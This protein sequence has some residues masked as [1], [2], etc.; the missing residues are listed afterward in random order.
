VFVGATFQPLACSPTGGTLGAAG[1]TYIFRDFPGAG[2][3]G[4]WYH[5]AL[6]DAQFGAQLINDI[7]IISFFNSDIDDNDP[8]CLTGRTWYYG[9]D[10]NQGTNID[11]L[12]VVMH[13][14]AH[15]L[16][17]SNF[18]NEATGTLTGGF[19]DIYTKFT[20]DLTTGLT[21]DVMTNAERQASA[22]NSGN[23][24]W[25]GGNVTAEAPFVLGPRPSVSVLNP[26]SIKGSY[27]AQQASYG[28][29]LSGG[30]GTT[31]KMVVVNDG[32]GVG[33]D[34]CE[35]IQNNLNGKLALIDRGTCA[36]VTKTLNAQAAGAKGVIV[37][38]NVATGLPGM[39]GASTAAT[40]PSVGVSLAEGTAMKNA[41]QGNSVAKL[42]LD[43]SVAAG[44]EQGFVRLYAPNPVALGSSISHWD[45][46]ASPNLLME[47]FINSDLE[48]A[49]TRD[50]TPA[51]FA[52]IGWILLP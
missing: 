17:F 24:V 11:F 52:D 34:G 26:K 48:S 10:N 12:A 50:L 31:G 40:I 6:A 41:A 5:S 4:T 51:L 23:V 1:A 21:W 36:F 19:P 25:N 29:P 7:D 20:L 14:I 2:F 43:D 44:T 15:G 49:T 8:N 9:F 30:G 33:S 18:A 3:T 42:I 27:E 32:V 46:T 38:N 35:P 28:P 22:I 37:V 47:P 39:G 16:G 13:E 45:T